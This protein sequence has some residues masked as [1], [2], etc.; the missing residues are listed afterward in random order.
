MD[1]LLQIF[2]QASKDGYEDKLK[3][4][5]PDIYHNKSQIECY[6]FCQQYEDYFAIC[7]VTRPNQIPFAAFFLQNCINFCWQQHK[8]K[9]EGENL[10]L[11]F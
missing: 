2:F 10:T 3:V 11:I 4:K 7:K 9:I 1:H 6:N 8:Q 5:T